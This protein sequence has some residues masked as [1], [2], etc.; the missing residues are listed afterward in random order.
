MDIKQELLE[1][2][3]D[4]K[5]IYPFPEDKAFDKFIFAYVMN[6]LIEDSKNKDKT[7]DI[8]A[9]TDE[10]MPGQVF[11]KL[12]GNDKV[13][14]FNYSYNHYKDEPIRHHLV[15]YTEDEEF[16]LACKLLNNPERL[17]KLLVK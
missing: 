17:F 11:D 12:K 8:T 10:V 15:I 4:V 16:I 6:D 14:L 1:Q 5:L 7:L 13:T 3:K 9:N 2:Y